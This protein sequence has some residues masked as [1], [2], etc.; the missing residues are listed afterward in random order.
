MLTNSKEI[1]VDAQKNGYAIGH[2]NTSDLEITKAIIQ[3][4]QVMKSPIIVAT[5]EKAISYAGLEELAEIIKIEA[6]KVSVPVILHLD[7][8]KSFEICE[9]AIQNGYTSIMI[10]GSDLEYNENVQLT[11]KV[12]KFAHRFGIPVEG[13]IGAIGGQKLTDPDEASYF[14]KNT[15]VDSLAVAIGNNHGIPIPGEKLDFT[16][17]TEIR[18]QV[19]IPLILHGASSTPVDDIK[20]AI[21][22]GICK[23]NIDTDIKIAF[24]NSL[25]EFINANQNSFDPKEM[26]GTASQSVEKVVIDKIKLFGSDNKAR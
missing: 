2:F 6:E 7:H 15:S 11:Q 17:L 16:R 21:A 10:D 20:K 24:T 26:I 12:V 22:S 14:A 3:A 25:K 4:G 5:S 1:L 18:K 23:I 8:A 13:E 9:R 19:S